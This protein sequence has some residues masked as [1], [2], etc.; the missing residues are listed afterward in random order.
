MGIRDEHLIWVLKQILKTPIKMPGGNMAYPNKG[1]PQGGIISPLLANIVLNELDHWVESQ[2][3]ENPVAKR[4]SRDRGEKGIDKSD[5]YEAMKKTNLKEMFIVR[6]ADDF[7]IFCRT[8]SQAEQTKIAIAQW[9]KERLKLELSP[10]KTR[11]VNVKRRYSEFLGFKIKVHKKGK[12]GKGKRKDK[13]VVKSHMADKAVKNAKIK[14]IEQAK[15]IAKPPKNSR[16]QHETLL[17]NSKVIGIQEYYRIATNISIDCGKIQWAVSR[18]LKNRLQM[19]KGS[20]LVKNGRELTK[21][22][23]EKYGKSKQLRYLAASG[24]PIYPIG[25]VKKKNPLTKKRSICCYTPEGRQG[26]HDNLR[27]NTTLIHLMEKQPLYDR[28]VEYADNRISL[29]SAQWGKCLVTG[30]EFM[31]LEDIHCHHKTLRKK[32]GTDKYDNLIL[33]LESVHRLIHATEQKTIYKYL[34]TLNLNNK[35]LKKLNELRK[36]ADND[37]IT[38]PCKYTKNK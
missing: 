16:E 21:F 2:W 35:Q 6:Y 12:T 17:Y 9:L 33:V 27:L 20:R 13:Y 26:L 5:G 34:Q 15:R 14:F 24:E 28:S 25:F 32:G 18:I 19:Q 23:K 29:F 11:I 8:K 7:R 36:L 22:E 1:T 4:Y 38:I 31:T 10:E 3:Q 37:E 30:R